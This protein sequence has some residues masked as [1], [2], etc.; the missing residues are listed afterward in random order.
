MR[1][2]TTSVVRD[3]LEEDDTESVKGFKEKVEVN[4]CPS[5]GLPESIQ[6]TGYLCCGLVVGLSP[7]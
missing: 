7:D 1:L 5:C 2:S 3:S 6:G 4:N